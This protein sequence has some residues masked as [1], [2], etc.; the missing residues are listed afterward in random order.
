MKG[1]MVT[2]TYSDESIEYLQNKYWPERDDVTDNELV[3]KSVRLFKENWRK[4]TG[5]APKIWLISEHGHKD[6]ERIHLHGILFTEINIMEDHT[7]IHGDPLN[8]TNGKGTRS[9]TSLLAK[10]WGRGMVHTGTHCDMGTINYIMK[11]VTKRD[12]DHPGYVPKILPSNGIG[13]DYIQQPGIKERHKFKEEKT[14]TKYKAL[15]G[16]EYG[17]PTYYKRKLWNDEERIKLWMHLIDKNER[18][19]LGTRI[20]ISKSDT[21]YWSALS[22][23]QHLNIQWG[24]ASPKEWKKLKYRA[25]RNEFGLLLD[26]SQYNICNKDLFNTT[27]AEDTEN[28]FNYGREL[29]E[30]E[31][32]YIESWRDN[33]KWRLAIYSKAQH[34]HIKNGDPEYSTDWRGAIFPKKFAYK[35]AFESAPF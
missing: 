16:H 15:T 21:E 31:I 28:W 34:T 6:T 23:A 32:K 18:W 4:H 12:K 24:Y 29:N 26:D 7:N 20:D 14:C 2:F 19:V 11:Y 8:T 25:Q 1:Y 9:T 33:E 30:Q 10:I 3:V 5:R 17:L 35:D 27:L 22:H 13:A